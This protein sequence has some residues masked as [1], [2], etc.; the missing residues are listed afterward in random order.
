[1]SVLG[2]EAVSHG[3]T[4]VLLT[5]E[6]SLQLQ[7]FLFNYNITLNIAAAVNIKVQLSL[8]PASEVSN[9]SMEGWITPGLVT[10]P[11]LW[12]EGIKRHRLELCISCL[13]KN[14]WQNYPLFFHLTKYFYNTM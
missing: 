4:A 3:S 1:M 12:L 14:I 11:V 10:H 9:F 5:D 2:I 6:P 7:V 13:I 8:S